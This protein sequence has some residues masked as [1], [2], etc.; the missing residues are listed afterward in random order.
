[1]KTA[2]TAALVF[3]SL[4][5]F[6]CSYGP[7]NFA[8]EKGDLE[9]E[10]SFESDNAAGVDAVVY[11]L[12][13]PDGTPAVSFRSEVNGLSADYL[14][15]GSMTAGSWTVKAGLMTAETVFQ[16]HEGSVEIYKDGKSKIQIYAVY[17]GSDYDI[18][19]SSFRNDM[20]YEYGEPAF[21]YTSAALTPN[22]AMDF[23]T[24]ALSASAVFYIEGAGFL[25]NLMQ[26]GL[27]YPD[28]AEYF[29]GNQYS[30]RG[31]V[32][33]HEI[34]DAEVRI[35]RQTD[36]YQAVFSGVCVLKMRDNS[37]NSMRV[38]VASAYENAEQGI[39]LIIGCD[40]G[41]TVPETLMNTMEHRFNWSI[42]DPSC[43]GTLLAFIVGADSQIMYPATDADIIVTGSSGEFVLGP[44]VV[45]D[46]D[47]FFIIASMEGIVTAPVT[48]AS[49]AG[50]STDRFR[51]AGFI[52]AIR[53]VYG[54]DAGLVTFSAVGFQYMP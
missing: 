6:S 46:G 1:M 22:M 38:E 33:S 53:E 4:L 12:T 10:F 9:I 52:S 20:T 40:G 14:S 18:N 44:G 16:S 51:P 27:C 41:D 32:F 7:F 5:L 43:S 50:V 2:F 28:G 35:F 36:D 26:V 25:D 48:D 39:P 21:T 29:I 30:S 11:E 23:R 42:A 54:P 3:C 17:N 19:F 47:Y 24:G 37:Y 8:A 45:A 49:S 31:V 34:S 13:P 15:I